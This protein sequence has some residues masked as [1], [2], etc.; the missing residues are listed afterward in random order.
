MDYYKERPHKLDF[1]YAFLEY[2][3]D[4]KGV[5]IPKAPNGNIQSRLL[6]DIIMWNIYDKVRGAIIYAVINMSKTGD[7]YELR[8]I[9]SNPYFAQNE[10][11]AIDAENEERGIKAKAHIENILM[12]H[13]VGS[14]MFK[15]SE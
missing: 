13:P 8:G 6:P 9:Y 5:L 2:L 11:E 4:V 15:K 1:M 7:F 12:N 10:C 3:N 14:S